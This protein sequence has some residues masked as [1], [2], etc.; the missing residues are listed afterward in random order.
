ML[1]M[2]HYA[3]DWPVAGGD[4]VP[5]AAWFDTYGITGESRSPSALA[6]NGY[7]MLESY[8]AGL[9]PTSADPFL[10]TSIQILSDGKLQ[11]TINGM[12]TDLNDTARTALYRVFRMT[13]VGGTESEIA[14]TATSGVASTI[15][16]STAPVSDEKAFY[17]VKVVPDR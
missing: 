10:I 15:W 2:T 17:K 16:T 9:D 11:L 7:T 4:T 14:G 6:A 13:A 3:D 12:R 1:T 5:P 8:D